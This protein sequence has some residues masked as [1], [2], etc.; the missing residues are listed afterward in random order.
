MGNS[1]EY[2]REWAAANPGKIA[3]YSRR[4][5]ARH[6]KARERHNEY[7]R[8]YV[9]EHREEI[10]EYQRRYRAEHPKYVERS[11]EKARERY[12]IYV[13]MHREDLNKRAREWR[14]ANREKVNASLRRRQDKRSAQRRAYMRAHPEKQLER[15]RRNRATIQGRMRDL[16]H[17]RIKKAVN[18]T[19]KSGRTSELIG[20]SIEQLMA[21]LESQFLPGMS[22]D[23]RGRWGWHIDHIRPCASFDLTDPLQ[24]KMCFHYTNLRPLWAKEN[25]SKGSRWEDSE[26]GICVR[27]A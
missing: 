13:V 8:K 10:S 15:S 25:L 26:G 24:Q 11:R 7:S 20:C 14:A 23:N 3:E 19:V 9:R 22:W 18:G 4:Y 1:K 17:C 12:R 2:Q 5:R 6:P 21:H 27:T 16:L